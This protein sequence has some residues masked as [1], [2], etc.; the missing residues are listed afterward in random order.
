MFCY[1]SKQSL[2]KEQ[3]HCDNIKWY[4]VMYQIHGEHEW[5]TVKAAASD[6]EKVV[7]NLD[8]STEYRLRVVAENNEPI[9]ST[10]PPVDKVTIADGESFFM[11]SLQF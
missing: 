2:E 10:S 4:Q 1:L 5:I 8:H 11:C 6:T 3:I 9:A 7:P